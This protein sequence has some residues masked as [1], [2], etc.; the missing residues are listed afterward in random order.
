M[1]LTDLK[2]KALAKVIAYRVALVTLML[3]GLAGVASAADLNASV[4]PIIAE[5]TKL[6][7]PLLAVIIGAI[8]I[9]VTLAVIGFIIALLA[10][11]LQ[12]IKI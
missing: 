11:I 2:Q 9:V 5:V 6:F 7:V 8:P 12:K 1:S 4:A 10:V 3:S